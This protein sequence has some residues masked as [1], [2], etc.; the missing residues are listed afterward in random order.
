[1][2]LSNVSPGLCYLF[3][4]HE[5]VIFLKNYDLGKEKIS[6]LLLNFSIPCIISMLVGALYNIVDQIFIG[7]GVGYLGNTATNIVYPFTV[8]ALS[9]AL[10]FGDGASALFSLSLGSKDD[11]KVSK[12]IG[13]AVITLVLVSLVL[14]LFGFIFKGNILKLFGV[15]EASFDFA[16]DYLT[17]IL[18]GIPFYVIGQGLNG[19]IRAD[20][21]PRYAMI[22]TL[23]G[24]IL[25]IILDPIA[26]FALGMGI[27]GA[28]IATIVGQ[29]VTFIL[30]VLYFRKS[31]K[32]KLSKDS[33]KPDKE[34]IKREALLGVSSFITQISIVLVIAVCNNLVVKY[35]SL[36]KYGADI[37]LSAIGI[38]MKV[39]GIVIALVIG[40][41]IGGQP[42]IG[43][44]YG[45]GNKKRVKETF[46]LIIRT[47]LFVGV[48]AFIVF[49]VF[50]Q[51]IINIFGSESELYNEY[52]LY[53]FRIYLSGITLT[54]I[55]KTCSIYLQAIGKSFKSMF[56]SV[57]RDVVLFIPA[58]V[59]LAKMFGVV[60]M[61]WAALVADVIAFIIAIFM[62]FE[63]K[64]KVSISEVKNISEVDVAFIKPM[65][66]TISR[67][68]G[69]GGRYVGKLLAEKLGIPCY[70]KEIIVDTARE[71]GLDIEYI[72]EN[73]QIKN[74]FNIY[75]NNDDNIYLC[76]S[77]VIKNLAMKPCIIIGRCADYILK[78]R[79]DV[80]NVFLY[81]SMDKKIDRVTKYY[82]INV[83]KAKNEI[84]KVNKRRAKHYEYY[85]NQKWNDVGNYDLAVNV[86]TLG[87]E[88]TAL[89]IKNIIENG[90]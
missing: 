61:L 55:T 67:E 25:N 80:Y 3:F 16:N 63:R 23:S 53:C 17:V 84:N 14:T 48:I 72:K 31:K 1:V 60:G 4:A 27:K 71:S 90:K 21:S 56:I 37:P 52:A 88:N 81:S 11:K 44:N 76:E 7:W 19:I 85:T 39:F 10:L 5:R 68:Y 89:M 83:E 74:D 46:N 24:A 29:I 51:A 62:T 77:K 82:G 12:S 49:Q 59:V 38:V 34:V 18:I 50:P 13:N 70:D 32:F 86:D 35:G 2:V 65:V 41:S 79:N 66:I 40:T 69:S 73:E 28:A 47:N 75:Y 42:I 57:M 8:I 58:L 26:I 22:A 6:K 54:C 20:G 33:L 64:N 45:A 78:D 87:V 15:T 30:T 36:S 9:L 43:F